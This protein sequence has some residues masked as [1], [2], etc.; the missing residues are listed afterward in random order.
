MKPSIF[1]L[2]SQ[3]FGRDTP[4]EVTCSVSGEADGLRGRSCEFATFAALYRA[5]HAA[6]LMDSEMETPLNV[7]RCGFP[8]FLE[9]N[10]HHSRNLGLLIG[11]LVLFGTG[12]LPIRMV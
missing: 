5:F 2:P 1:L 12:G 4:I 10:S 6:G 7:V 11:S 3:P 9:T 8:V